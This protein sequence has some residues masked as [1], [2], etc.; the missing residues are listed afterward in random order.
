MTWKS[1]EELWDLMRRELFTAV[2]GDVLDALG[3]YHQFLPPSIRPLQ[4]DMV[5]VGRA[6]PVLEAD[7][8]VVDA[9]EARRATP[10]K[11]FGLM[12]EAL[13]DLKP[14]EVYVATGGSPRYALWGE[15]MA[16]RA[17][18]LGCGGAVLH[19]Y[20]RDTRGLL[21]LGFPVFSHGRYAQDQGAR[22]RVIDFR[23]PVEIE[24]VAV[25]PGDIV[26][27]DVDGVVVVPRAVEEETIRLALEKVH[28][29]NLV[30][31]AIEGGMSSAEAFRM[32]GVM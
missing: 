13:D 14:H 18:R 9:Q 11:P 19:G 21:R 17:S 22:G 8:F 1:D 25:C 20:S 6:M 28:K 10:Y 2:I 30:K 29:E 15:L 12:F 24:G 26:F 16:T 27:G 31:T 5:V 4:D 32:Y 23:V 3:L 7:C